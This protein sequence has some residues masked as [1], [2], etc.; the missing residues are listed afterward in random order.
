MRRSGSMSPECFPQLSRAP[1]LH[2]QLKAKLSRVRHTESVDIWNAA[3][4]QSLHLQEA[5]VRNRGHH[6]RHIRETVWTSNVQNLKVVGHVGDG[7]EPLFLHRKSSALLL[8]PSE[9][10]PRIVAR[11]DAV[12][13]VIGTRACHCEFRYD[14]TSG[15][16]G[17][18]Q[19]AVAC[20]LGD[21]VRQHL[22]QEESCSQ[23][24]AR[25]D[26]KLGV[27]RVTK[28]NAC[29]HVLRFSL[30]GR[31]PGVRLEAFQ[32]LCQRMRFSEFWRKHHGHLN[33]SIRE[34]CNRASL[35]ERLHERGT[36]AW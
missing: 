2:V 9:I 6:C 1:R 19:S 17:I 7:D 14:A 25:F 3:D 5:N 35:A 10:V 32:I 21:L 20:D 36:I 33:P 30:H 27:R 4:V 18:G 24:G 11:P 16:R 8:K 31:L 12:I 22:L 13:L 26:T 34:S 15:S 29:P 23:R 28:P